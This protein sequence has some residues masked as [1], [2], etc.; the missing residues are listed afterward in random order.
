MT[1]GGGKGNK[2]LVGGIFLDG[3]DEQMFGWS[4]GLPPPPVK[5]PCNLIIIFVIISNDLVVNSQ[6]K[7]KISGSRDHRIEDLHYLG[8]VNNRFNIYSKSI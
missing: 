6:G 8:N 7:H 3:G 1:F 5:K 2:K 4:G